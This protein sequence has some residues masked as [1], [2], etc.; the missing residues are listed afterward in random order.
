M[1]LNPKLTDTDRLRHMRDAA[2][3]ALRFVRGRTRADLDTDEM[4][5]FALVRALEIIGEAADKLSDPAHAAHPSIPWSEIIG[6]RHKLTHG[7]FDVDL[8]IVWNGNRGT[9]GPRRLARFCAQST[10][11]SLTNGP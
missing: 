8:G 11:R 1:S 9:P 7:Y 2:C 3:A 10:A 6:M 5:A 4:L